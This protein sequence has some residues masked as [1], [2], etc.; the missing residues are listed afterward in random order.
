MSFLL[1]FRIARRRIWYM[2]GTSSQLGHSSYPTHGQRPNHHCSVDLLITSTFRAHLHDPTVY[3]EPDRFIPERFLGPDGRTSNI[4]DPTKFMFGYGRRCVI[5]VLPMKRYLTGNCSVC[6]GKHY[7][8]S[9]LFINIATVLHAFDLTPA[10]D[11]HG[12]EVRIE[13]QMTDS[14]I[15]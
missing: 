11:E 9:A 8:D 15:S 3:P 14:I 6:P 13:P 5:V 1:A 2:M 4:N 10:L 12:E 7:A